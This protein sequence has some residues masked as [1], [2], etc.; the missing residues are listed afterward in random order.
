MNKLFVVAGIALVALSGRTASAADLGVVKAEQLE[1]WS[2]NGCYGGG[3]GGAG[4]MND[5]YT[6]RN[7]GGGLAGGQVGCNFQFDKFIIGFELDGMWSGESNTNF[8]STGGF[9]STTMTRNRW[10]ADASMRLGYAAVDRALAYAKV[11]FTEGGFS[12]STTTNAPF[13]QTGNVNLPG[14]LLGGGLEYAITPNWSAKGEYNFLNYLGQTVNLTCGA[15]CAPTSATQ[16]AL[17]HV[18][19]VGFN[20]KFTH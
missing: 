18:F 16:S 19:K 11:G 17:V 9:T 14:F 2:W 1:R 3:F 10:D 12:Y 8:L 7:G 5:S 13:N 20:Y 15:G 6:S 4:M